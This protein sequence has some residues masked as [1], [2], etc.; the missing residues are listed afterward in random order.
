MVN[1]FISHLCVFKISKFYPGPENYPELVSLL[2]TQE[3]EYSNIVG[4]AREKAVK[5]GQETVT[6]WF[7]SSGYLTQ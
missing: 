2:C 7:I 6:A 5:V 4:R 3:T 1:L